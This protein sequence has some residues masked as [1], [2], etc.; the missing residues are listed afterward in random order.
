LLGVPPKRFFPGDD[1]LDLALDA[2]KY[3]IGKF[4]LVLAEEVTGDNGGSQMS[5]HRSGLVSV[6]ESVDPGLKVLKVDHV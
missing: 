4:A 5:G 3:F 6:S 2:S 1:P